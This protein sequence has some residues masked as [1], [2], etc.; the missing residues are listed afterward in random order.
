[1][2]SFIFR[3][4]ISKLTQTYLVVNNSEKL[5]RLSFSNI[6]VAYLG[7]IVILLF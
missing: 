1:M 7:P 5:N 3:K 4:A 6:I 2:L